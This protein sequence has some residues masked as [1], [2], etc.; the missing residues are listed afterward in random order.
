[1]KLASRERASAYLESMGDDDVRSW[2]EGNGLMTLTLGSL[3]H[4]FLV[5]LQCRIEKTPRA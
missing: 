3:A 5:R 1:M 4:F 2:R